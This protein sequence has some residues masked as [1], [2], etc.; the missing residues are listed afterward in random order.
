MAS[1]VTIVI[2]DPGRLAAIREGATLPGRVMH[3]TSTSLGSAFESIRAYRPKVVAVDAGFAE[4]PSGAAFVDRIDALGI[5]ARSTLLIAEENGRWI[6]TPRNG[7]TVHN[8]SKLAVST[9]SPPQPAIAVAAEPINTRRAPRFVVRA[10]IDVSVE[11]ASATLVDMSVLG[12]Q[13][14]SV[15]VLRPGQRICVGLSDTAETLNVTAQIAWSTYEKPRLEVEPH[16]RVG[17]EFT[18]AAQQ[19]LE[20]YRQRNCTDQPTPFRGR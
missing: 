6:T 2:A 18:D 8:A 19:A 7:T 14:V 13:L 15:P 12:A 5:T 10:P 9:S 16:Y 4:T 17:L 11:G 1:D 3:F 20:D